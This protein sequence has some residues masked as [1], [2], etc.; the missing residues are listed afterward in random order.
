MFK[1]RLAQVPFFEH[2][3]R[4]E[5]EL[6]GAQTD[7]LDVPEGKVLAREGDFGHEFFVVKSGTAEVSRGGEV[8][9]QIGEGDFF[10]EMALLDEEKRTATVTA[11]S[12]MTV[13]VMSRSA[14]RALDRSQPDIHRAVCD[15][16]ERH[17]GRDAAREQPP[18][19]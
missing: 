19:G 15:A 11:T 4:K 1:P 6:V 17:R 12:P 9:N 18:V 14:F 2:L 7:E 13:I 3:K 10:G 16:I 8:L 5:L